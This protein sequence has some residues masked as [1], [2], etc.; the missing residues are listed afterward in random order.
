MILRQERRSANANFS[1]L[2]SSQLTAKQSI[3]DTF[4]SLGVRALVVAAIHF[5]TGLLPPL[6]VSSLLGLMS[7]M[8]NP[9]AQQ[10]LIP[11]K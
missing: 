1:L 7:V 3:K 2:S 4:K 5:K 11:A 6:M 8:E 10:H 9:H